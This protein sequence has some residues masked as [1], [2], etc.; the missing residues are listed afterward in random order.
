MPLVEQRCTRLL[1]APDVA[2]GTVEYLREALGIE[3]AATGTSSSARPDETET[4]FFRLPD[5]GRI[6][7]IETRRTAYDEEPRSG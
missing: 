1:E 3:Q 7:V 4:R 6:S 5:N 2:E